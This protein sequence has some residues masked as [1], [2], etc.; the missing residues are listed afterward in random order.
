MLPPQKLIPSVRVSPPLPRLLCRLTVLP[1]VGDELD[2]RNDRV[3]AWISPHVCCARDAQQQVRLPAKGREVAGEEVRFLRTQK[4]CLRCFASLYTRQA[5]LRLQR[6][7]AGSQP[8]VD[9][10]HSQHAALL[11]WFSSVAFARLVLVGRFRPPC[12]RRSLSPAWFSSVAFA[13]RC[14]LVA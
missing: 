8:G 14:V 12:S 11:A 7:R 4:V 3:R 13:P 5:R 1:R 10:L 2:D 6:E 9:W